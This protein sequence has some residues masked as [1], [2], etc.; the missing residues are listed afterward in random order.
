MSVV[1][2]LSADYDLQRLP[3]KKRSHGRIPEHTPVAHN[4]RQT[5]SLRNV[6]FVPSIAIAMAHVY[7]KPTILQVSI[8]PGPY[9]QC[10]SRPELRSG[11]TSSSS[12]VVCIPRL[13]HCISEVYNCSR[14]R[15]CNFVDVKGFP[16]LEERIRVRGCFL[17]GLPHKSFARWFSKGCLGVLAFINRR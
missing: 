1:I 9:T 12:L 16:R 14:P 4:A 17:I 13:P 5:S 10:I 6:A 11:S 8:R 3:Y 15:K 7:H 2:A